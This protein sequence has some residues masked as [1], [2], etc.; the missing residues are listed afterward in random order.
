MIEILE[1][2]MGREGEK[3][4]ELTTLRAQIQIG[5]DQIDRGETVPLDEVL[6]GMDEIIAKAKNTKSCT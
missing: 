2:L 3:V 5:L 6:Q 4:E 1:T